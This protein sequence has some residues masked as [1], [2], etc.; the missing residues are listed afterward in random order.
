MA[1]LGN[2]ASQLLSPELFSYSASFRTNV[3]EFLR[4]HGREVQL[5]ILHIRCWIVALSDGTQLQVYSQDVCESTLF[6]DQCRIIGRPSP[7]FS[8]FGE[9]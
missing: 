2:P 3:H 4:A 8:L 5:G 1:A 6:C 9:P 7:R